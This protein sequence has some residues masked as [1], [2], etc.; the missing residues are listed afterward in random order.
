MPKAPPSAPRSLAAKAKSGQIKLTWLAPL[1]NG[2][3]GITTY[4]VWRGT[5]VRQR[6]EDRHSRQRATFVDANVVRRTTYYY[7]VRAV[8]G[9]GLTG[10]YS[11]EVSLV[12]ASAAELPRATDGRYPR[13]ALVD[14][15]LRRSSSVAEQGT[16]KPL[17]GGSNPPS[18]TNHHLGRSPIG[19]MRIIPRGPIRLSSSSS[20]IRPDRA[21]RRSA[22]R[23]R[24]R[25]RSG[26]DRA[27]PT[28]WRLVEYDVP[29]GS[30]S[31]YFA[32][33]A[34]ELKHVTWGL[35]RRLDDRSRQPAAGCPPQPAQG[36][37]SDIRTGRRHP[38]SG[39]PQYTREAARMFCC[40][41][42]SASRWRSTRDDR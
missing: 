2:G 11:N 37:L 41:A 6:G 10:P 38:V 26:C 23:R 39:A 27:G 28:G 7:V 21:G 8:N 40:P 35:I 5:S 24:S 22:P 30:R 3:A 17:V 29:V 4:E 20:A 36:A 25:G 42:R 32:F 15:F 34:P 33:V 14:G 31:R 13:S 12:A 1:S 9:F 18:A 19:W 16:H